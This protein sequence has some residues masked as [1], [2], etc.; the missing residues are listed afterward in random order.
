VPPDE[1][2]E[3]GRAG[4]GEG[5][6][7]DRVDDRGPPRRVRSSRALRVTWDDLGGVREPEVVHG[8]GLE[9]AHLDAAVATVAGAV[10]HRD[11][12]PGQAG[13]A[14]QE[15]GLVGVDTEQV[16]GLLVADQELGRVGVGVQRVGG[17][18]HA[19]KV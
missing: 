3:P 11:A 4:L 13:A 1:V 15:P 16:V 2:S 19:G 18:D 8:D 14:V 9:G 10:Q 7:G 12:V 17:H 6:A 5:E